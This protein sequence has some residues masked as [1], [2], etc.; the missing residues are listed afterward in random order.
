MLSIITHASNL[1]ITLALAHGDDADHVLKDTFF[2]CRL[3]ATGGTADVP[4]EK[5]QELLHYVQTLTSPCGIRLAR[6]AIGD[7][8]DDVALSSA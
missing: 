5:V 8:A 3:L 7:T 6:I 4:I 2:A 1:G